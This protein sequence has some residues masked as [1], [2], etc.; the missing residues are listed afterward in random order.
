MREYVVSQ[1]R[2]VAGGEFTI[3]EVDVLAN[4][5]LMIILSSFGDLLDGGFVPSAGVLAVWVISKVQEIGVP[6]STE[7]GVTIS[8]GA[9]LSGSSAWGGH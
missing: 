4:N 3:R 5:L 8:P 6:T 1:T 2:D 9:V 7:L